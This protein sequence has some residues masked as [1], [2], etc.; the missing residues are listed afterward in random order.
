[1]WIC[2]SK[3]MTRSSKAQIWKRWS[4][5]SN[6]KEW[7]HQLEESFVYGD[8]EKGS[9]GFLKP[10]R[11][12]K[13]KFIV[14]E[15]TQFTSFTSRSLLPFCTMD[16]SHQLIDTSEGLWVEHKI[17]FSGPLD[18]LFG[19][20]IGKKLKEELPLAVANLVRLSENTS[21]S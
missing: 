18:F 17:M 8:F 2:E 1:M 15:C 20:L 19:K 10:K 14:I 5:V 9:K 16:V 11:G 7:D 4:D 3:M 6:W 13:A 21:L 12:P